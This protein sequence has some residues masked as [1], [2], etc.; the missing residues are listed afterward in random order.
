LEGQGHKDLAL[1]IATDPEHRF[2]LSLSLGNLDTALEIAREANAEHKWKTVGDTAL[3]AWDLILAEECF[4]NAK[5]IGSLLLLRTATGNQEGLKELAGSAIL[6]G[7]NN[8][9]FAALWQTGDIEE[10]TELLVKTAR[11][12]E[13]ALFTQTYK[14]SLTTEVVRKW[15]ESLKENKKG[16]LSEAI[17]VPDE[18][19]ELFPEWDEYLRLEG[20][21]G[22]DLIDV[23]ETEGGEAEH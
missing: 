14:P 21:G 17:G 1:E 18:D 20:E 8:I 23:G 16:K 4:R 5:D 22:G 19:E 13:A 2:D 9:A 10:C 3:L 15:K 11:I 6:T 12:P 7:A